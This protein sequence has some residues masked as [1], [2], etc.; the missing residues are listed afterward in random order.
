MA[1]SSILNSSIIRTVLTY[2]VTMN[3]ELADMSLEEVLRS[4]SLIKGHRSQHEREIANLLQLLTVQYSSTSETRINDRLEKIE[5]YTNRLMDMADYLDS[6]KY[7]KARDHKEE[8]DEFTDTLDKCSADAFSVLHNRYANAGAAAA[9]PQPAVA[10]P[11]SKPS[12]SEL[13]PEKLRHDSS[14]SVFRTWKKQFKAYY[15]A[16]QLHTLPCSQQQAYLSNCLDDSLRARINR[17][18]TATTPVFSP[19]VGLFFQSC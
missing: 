16:T 17:E 7:T 15:D 1:Q 10:R 3:L 8:V 4:Y 13:R 2:L 12:S 14:T 11:S 19:I 5:K 6:I 9:P 18:A